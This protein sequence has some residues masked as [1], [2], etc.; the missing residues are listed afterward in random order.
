MQRLTLL[1]AMLLGLAACS[2]EPVWAPDEAVAAAHVSTS[3]PPTI[4]LFSMINTKSGNGG[5][6]ALL[7][8]ASERVLFD[9][10]GSF[11]HPNLP[12]RNDVVYGMTDAAVDFYTDFHSRESWRVVRQDLVVPAAVAEQA[13]AMVKA[14]GA[15]PKAYC[16]N[17][18]SSILREL[19]GFENVK[20]TMFP[21]KLMDQFAGYR[22]VVT[23]E[24]HDNDPDNGGTLVARGI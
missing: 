14:N 13:L 22:G 4:T 10:A 19:P 12:E 5:H 20:V 3:N 17:S 15:V 11:Y 21:D 9:P 6:T 7:V 18:T 16:A 23:R 8:D 2:A 24:F 1:F